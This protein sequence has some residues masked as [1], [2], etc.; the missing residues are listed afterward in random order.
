MT[1]STLLLPACLPLAAHQGEGST[2]AFK[3]QC[4]LAVEINSLV[5]VAVGGAY[6]KN[7]KRALLVVDGWRCSSFVDGG[8]WCS[9]YGTE[10][11][12][13]SEE[14]G[15]HGCLCCECGEGGCE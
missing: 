5:V 3:G 2:G 12:E 14:S 13:E 8:R 4:A 1:C 10:A 9:G 6:A 15:A 7:G 11:G